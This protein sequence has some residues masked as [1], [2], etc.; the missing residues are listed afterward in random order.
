[1]VRLWREFVSEKKKSK[2]EVT[3]GGEEK[4]LLSDDYKTGREKVEH[5]RQGRA[6]CLPDE[7]YSF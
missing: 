7:K 5:G 1:M 2:K 6:F 3:A 4:N